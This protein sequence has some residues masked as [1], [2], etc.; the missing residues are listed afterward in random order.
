MAGGRP[1]SGYHGRNGQSADVL[2]SAPNDCV[3]G[4][5]VRRR[6]HPGPGPLG[7]FFFEDAR[8]VLCDTTVEMTET[9]PGNIANVAPWQFDQYVVAEA[10]GYA[11]PNNSRSSR[12]TRSRGAPRCARMH[13]RP[14]GAPQQRAVTHRRGARPGRRRP[15]SRAAGARRPPWRG[16]CPS[17]SPRSHAP[18]ARPDENAPMRSTRTLVPGR[19]QLQVS[20]EPGLVRG[21]GRWPAAPIAHGDEVMAMLAAVGRA[22]VGLEPARAGSVVGRRHA[23]TR[24]R[25]RSATCWAGSSPRAPIRS[26]TTSAPSV[27]WLGRVAIWAVELTARGAMVPLL[28]RRTRRGG[29][30]ER[31]Q[32]FVLRA[33]DAGAGRRRRLERMAESM[34]GSVRALDR[35]V[36]GGALTRSALTGMVDAI[37]RDGARRVEVPA[38]PP[39]VRTAGD[40]GEAFLGRLDGSAFDAPVGIAGEI[41]TAASRAGARSV[42][43]PHEPTDRPARRARRR[44]CMAPRGDRAG[45]AGAP[46]PIEQAIVTAEVESSA[47]RRRDHA[48]RAHGARV[49]ASG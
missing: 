12:P 33:L 38:P 28:R 26:A 10:D 48:P 47:L 43:D 2:R 13:A 18:G 35:K 20:W 36:D 44:R 5:G 11:T 32:R 49:P 22:R 25:S 9:M 27:R 14:G 16:A 37:C 39:R 4:S 6:L 24:S 31:L 19:T 3:S 29:K 41:E 30:A 15:R 34:P 23:P 40:V 17:A 42:T 7:P 46:R 8:G 21:V 45:R 1:G